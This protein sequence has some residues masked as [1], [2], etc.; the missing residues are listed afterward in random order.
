L[1]AN[2][3][4]QLTALVQQIDEALRPF[5]PAG[6]RDPRLAR[7]LQ[8]LTPSD[9]FALASDLA[10]D[11]IDHTNALLNGTKVR[12]GAEPAG[13]RG[14]AQSNSDDESLVAKFSAGDSGRAAAARSALATYDSLDRRGLFGL[15]RPTRESFV[16]AAMTGA[17]VTP[18]RGGSR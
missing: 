9:L 13:W 8:Y 4:A 14:S 3:Q 15:T 2:S 16:R 10:R 5:I 18:F 6:E 11:L 7:G 12:D 1:P 17:D